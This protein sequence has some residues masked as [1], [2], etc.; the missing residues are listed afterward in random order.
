MLLLK[1]RKEHTETEERRVRE[2]FRL[3]GI[4]EISRTL[5]QRFEVV[6]FLIAGVGVGEADSRVADP[7]C[8]SPGDALSVGLVL[9]TREVW[10][11]K[12]ATHQ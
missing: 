9:T 6:L 12:I 7:C 3:S 8:S 1:V 10:I 2:I 11:L 5:P 4:R